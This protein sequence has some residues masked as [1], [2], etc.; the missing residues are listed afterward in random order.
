MKDRTVILDAIRRLTV[1]DPAS[2]SFTSPSFA[3]LAT[4]L[5]YASRGTV[6]RMVSE[7]IG[8]GLL[9]S[10]RPGGRGLVVVDGDDRRLDALCDVAMRVACE[11]DPELR[12]T[13][14][15]AFAETLARLG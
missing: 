14:R 6:H 15:R 12:T 9:I 10:T 5:G 4:E 3:E 1:R 2:G 8:E 13:F 11:S 7:L